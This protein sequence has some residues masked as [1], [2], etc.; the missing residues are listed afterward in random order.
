MNF[1]DG[2]FLLIDNSSFNIF[3]D[4][5]TGIISSVT[6]ISTI[7]TIKITRDNLRFID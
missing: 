5:F 2:N 4:L 6:S 3:D 7:L 1:E